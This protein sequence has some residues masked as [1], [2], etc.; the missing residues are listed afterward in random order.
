MPAPRP[1]HLAVALDGAGWHPAARHEPDARPDELFTA[2]YWT[3]LVREAERGLLDF[4]TFEDPLT[5]PQGRD[6]AVDR[7]TG[8]VHRRLDSV[9]LAT[10]AAAGSSRIG[11]IPTM[12]ANHAQP[13]RIAKAIGTLDHLSAGRAGWRTSLSPT[14][15]IPVSELFRPEVLERIAER[16]ELAAELVRVVRALWDGVEDEKAL[17][18]LAPG[19]FAPLDQDPSGDYAEA[20]PQGGS[21]DDWIIVRDA[22]TP[23]RPPQGNPVVFT[24]AHIAA[25]HRYGATA[26]DVVSVTPH[27]AAEAAR[28]V[29]EIRGYQQEA[30]R[31]GETVHVFADVVVFLDPEPGRA[32][33]RKASLDAILGSDYASDAHIAVGTPAEV[34]DLLLE[35]QQAGLTGFR[36]RPGSVP[37]DLTAV[38]RELVPELQRRGAFRSSYEAD[39]LRGLLGLDAD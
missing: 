19:R 6:E 38:T 9:L 30:G 32:A 27:D 14:R 11:L 28:T 24:L 12:P 35:W 18:E 13:F 3:E 17:L 29:Q 7:R 15:P 33:A 39:T 34:A 37:H 2:G 25:P 5:R 8:Q 26:A 36:L 4:V 21:A 22:S 23:P 16:F 31:A 20:P 10:L 1:L